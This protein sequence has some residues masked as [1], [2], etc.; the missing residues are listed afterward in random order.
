M[1]RVII[2]NKLFKISNP[3][4]QHFNLFSLHPYQPL[5]LKNDYLLRCLHSL[6]GKTN[7]EI[8]YFKERI[9]LVTN[10]YQRPLLITTEFEKTHYKT[11]KFVN[12]MSK[13]VDNLDVF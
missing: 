8:H 1:I 12:N 6:F 3:G 2:I 5:Q 9:R 11:G 13:F 7:P 10:G 4:L